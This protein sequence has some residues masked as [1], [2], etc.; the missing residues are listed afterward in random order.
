MRC[1]PAVLA[2]L[3]LA[4]CSDEPIAQSPAPTA[5]AAAPADFSETGE[6]R[7]SANTASLDDFCIFGI[8][9]GSGGSAAL[10]VLNPASDVRGIQR[11]LLFQSGSWTTIDGSTVGSRSQGNETLLSVNE[12]EFYLLPNPVLTGQ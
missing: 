12:T 7:C 5:Q 2:T 6:L 8:T 10:H 4:A 9:R 3:M 11:I 1:L